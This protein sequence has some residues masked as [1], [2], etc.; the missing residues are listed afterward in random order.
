MIWIGLKTGVQNNVQKWKLLKIGA[1]H[2]GRQ[3]A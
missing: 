1:S 3:K 2:D